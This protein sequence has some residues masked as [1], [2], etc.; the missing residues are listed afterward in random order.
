MKVLITGAA[1]FVG[2]HLVTYL[3]TQ[4]VQILG[5]GRDQKE[6]N[7]LKAMDVSALEMDIC[8]LDSIVAGIS[9]T[10]PDYIIHLAAQSSV[11]MSW[12]DRLGTMETNI[13]G[14]VKL[15]EGSIKA[16]INSKFL[17][18]GS[19][20]EY[21]AAR[22]EDMPL[23]EQS[24]LQPVNPYGVSKAIL[25]YLPKLYLKSSN[26]PIVHARSFNHIG[27]GQS[28][29]FVLSD[30]AKQIAG[31]EKGLRPPVML[32]GNLEPKRDFLDV[33][34]VVQAY[35]LLVQ[36]GEP[37]ETYNVCSGSCLSVREILDFLLQEAKVS[38]KVETDRSK[39]RPAESPVL[40]GD[41]SKLKEKG[42]TPKIPVTHSVQDVLNYWRAK[43]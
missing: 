21:G 40:Y 11:G 39:F 26:L 31:I 1:G 29:G 13:L 6:V 10:R 36:K 41:N 33:R 7:T 22:P 17:L 3:K 43:V 18:V 8:N 27:P 23:A 28:E 2:R 24:R 42:W 16:G 30:F 9:A 15:I 4:P 35:W 38:I 37:G 5:T 19:A 20:E 12:Q 25:G 32:V 14:T 34:D